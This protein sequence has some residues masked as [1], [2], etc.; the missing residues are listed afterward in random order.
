MLELVGAAV[1]YP[2][3][4]RLFGAADAVFRDGEIIAVT[5]GEG[6]GKTSFLKM[7]VGAAETEGEVL[8]NGV[9]AGKDRNAA[10]MVFDDG[11]LFPLRSAAYN[12]GF[13]LRLRKVPRDER[14][15]RVRA[16]AETMDVT[17]CL[18]FAVRKLNGEERRRISLSRLFVRDAS[19]IVIDEP[20]AGLSRASAERVWARLAPLLVEKARAG[21]TVV[22]STPDPAE[23]VSVSDRIVA[24]HGGEIRQCGTLK[25]FLDSPADIWA[26]QAIEPRYNVAICTLSD[27]NGVLSL[28]FGGDRALDISALRVRI[29]EGYAGREVYA[30]WYPRTGEQPLPAIGGEDAFTERTVLA[31]RTASGFML[32]TEGGFTAA[33]RDK[34]ETVDIRPS[35]CGLTLFERAGER[36]I[37]LDET[38]ERR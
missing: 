21:C 9:P 31:T 4:A 38:V 1:K 5:G 13:P 11:A 28:D 17:G 24:L 19:L 29:A 33:C 14:E 25:D 12:I 10:V 37:M 35:A 15:R 36:S 7:L 26:A 22:Y 16:A 23:A 18:P 30:G 3:G 8:I 34:A 27:E 6:S 2:Y 20:T 32:T